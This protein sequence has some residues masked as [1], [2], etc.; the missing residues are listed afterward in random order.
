MQERRLFKIVY[1]LLDKGCS[2]ASELSRMLEV[3]SRTIYRDLDALSAAGIPV[4]AEAGRNGGIRLMKDFVLDK[5]I[6]SEQEKQD[7]L[8]ALQNLSIASSDHVQDTLGKLSALFKLPAQDW[9]EIDFSRWGAHTHDQDKFELLKLAV[10]R[11]TAVKI[12]YIN[13]HG[14]RDERTVWPLKLLYKSKEWYLKA[15]CTKKQDFR[16]FKLNRIL[17]YALSE[18]SFSPM[19]F[20]ES[21]MP[22]ENDVFIRLHFT[23]EA[24]CRAYDEFEEAQIEHLENGDIIAC[25]FMPTDAWLTGYLLS[26]GPQVEILEPDFL[27]EELAA[28]AKEI[29]RKYSG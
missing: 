18:E 21:E 6:L 1:H 2:T 9:Y 15:F 4:Y 3:S 27:R 11:H 20:P 26:F 25:A 29:Y 8:S 7:I 28:Q 5:T 14:G 10:L 22:D 16:L 19:L 24:A 12:L 13:A 17:Q 23:K